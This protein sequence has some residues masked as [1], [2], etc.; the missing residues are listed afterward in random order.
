MKITNKTKIKGPY[1]DQTWE[2][3]YGKKKALF[4]FVVTPKIKDNECDHCG[5][6]CSP[7]WNCCGKECYDNLC[8]DARSE[9]MAEARGS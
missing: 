7:D 3:L 1:P 6:E 8:A 5:K 9:G 4:G 2:Q